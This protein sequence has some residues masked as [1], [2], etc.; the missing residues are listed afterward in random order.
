MD[1]KAVDALKEFRERDPFLRGLIG[2][3]GF[4]GDVV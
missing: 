4:K 2:L 3:I 1:R